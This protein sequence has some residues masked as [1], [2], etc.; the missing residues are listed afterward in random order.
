MTNGIFTGIRVFFVVGSDSLSSSKR[1]EILKRVLCSNGGELIKEAKGVDREAIV[2]GTDP[3]LAKG[4]GMPDGVKFTHPDWI[5]DCAQRQNLLKPVEF[6]IGSDHAENLKK[7]GKVFGARHKESDAEDSGLQVGSGGEVFAGNEG[8]KLANFRYDA[9]ECERA[10]PLYSQHNQPLIDELGKLE[11]ARYL[12]G[13]FRGQM[14]YRR[15]IAVLKAYPAKID[16]KS[17]VKDIRGVG[18]T[19]LHFIGEF[20]RTGRIAEAERLADDPQ[21]KVI[22]MFC[23]IYGVGP[24]TAHKWYDEGMRTLQDVRRYQ[25]STLTNSQKIGLDHYEDFNS[26]MDRRTVEAVAKGIKAVVDDVLTDDAKWN[27]T[28]VGGYARGKIQNNDVDMVL[29][30]DKDCHLEGCLAKLISELKRRGLVSEVMSMSEYRPRSENG[31]KAPEEPYDKALV[32]FKLPGDSNFR[33]VDI[34]LSEPRI[35]PFVQ[36]GWTGSSHFVRAL[37]S[38]SVKK[39]GIHLNSCGMREIA[40][41]RSFPAKNEQEIFAHLGLG[42]LDPTM[43]NC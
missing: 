13:N 31:R 20:L 23:K 1:I 7:R 28:I 18:E 32:T 42:Y 5:S 26:P 17:K 27:V 36:L 39:R 25:Y 43:R 30:S 38:Y 9:Y 37:R 19:T 16:S 33:R 35:F 14:G 2:I 4:L 21:L 8:E 12:Q 40:T 6:E 41:G 29:C 15:V 34:L 11:H 22:G 3:S 24:I 10:T